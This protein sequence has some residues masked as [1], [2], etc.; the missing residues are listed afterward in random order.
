M[1]EVFPVN[2]RGRIKCCGLTVPT[3]ALTEYFHI[4]CCTKCNKVYIN[5]KVGVFNGKSICYE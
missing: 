1:K 3:L 5:W 2:S 4:K